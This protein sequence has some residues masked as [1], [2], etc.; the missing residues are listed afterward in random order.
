MPATQT[1]YHLIA[2][3]VAVA[4]QRSFTKAARKL[5]IAKG[6]VSRAI[7]ELERQV[8]T[9]LVH[10]TTQVVA[11]ST[12]GA[13]LYERTA[14]LITALDEAVHGLPERTV[15]PSGELRLTAPYDFGLVV[16]PSVLAQFALRYP[17]VRVDVRL[18][19]AV[20][21]LV[22]D[23]YDIAIRVAAGA[24]RDS[25]LTARRLGPI[26]AAF[27]AA[28]SYL[29]RRGK[30]KALGD[31]RHEWIVFIPAS[32]APLKLPSATR[33]RFR[34]DDLMFVREL[35]RDGAGIGLL[36]HLIAAPYVRD[37]LLEEVPVA[38]LPR[39]RADLYL[40]YPSSGQVARKVAAFRDF[41][42]EC[43]KQA[44]LA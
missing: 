44:P 7:A 24:L 34:T 18:T 41:L 3:F 10:R 31:P 33:W 15:E 9:E 28:P 20:V 23:G 5:G 8:G 22:A 16:L 26:S 35:A 39:R 2:I 43:V 25:T 21:D 12:A 29:A 19:N 30:P 37:G 27:F 13:A 1:D 17:D 38:E 32:A 4:D 6:T 42:L 11:L 14:R 40:V 36:S